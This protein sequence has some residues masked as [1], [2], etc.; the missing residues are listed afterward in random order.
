MADEQPTPPAQATVVLQGKLGVK[1]GWQT[2]EFWLKLA[3]ILLSALF[4]SDV[5]PTSGPVS[6]VAAIA[7]SVLL[8]LGYTVS[9]TMIKTVLPVFA[10]ALAW[11]VAIP[12]CGA[13]AR[14]KTISTTLAVTNAAAD[15]FVKFDDEHQQAIVKL[16]GTR[17]EGEKR[18]LEW[19]ADQL[20]ASRLFAVAYKAIATAATA[21][22]DPSQAKMIE[23]AADLAGELK[24]LG[25]PLGK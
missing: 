11:S 3:A 19:R 9:R 15:A 16:A 20:T 10:L 4:A 17:E 22:D 25:V 2:S 13:S 12:G 5:I 23:A 1:P 7:A 18:L 14:Q 6:K 21:D 24:R 8:S